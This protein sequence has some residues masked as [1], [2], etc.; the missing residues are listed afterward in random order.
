VIGIICCSR[1]EGDHILHTV[2]QKYVTAA[3]NGAGGLPLLVPACSDCIA[4]EA[5]VARLDG[6]LVPGSRSNVE[7]H[8]YGGPPSAPDTPHDPARDN[9]SL[10]LLRAA[11]KAD[12]PVLAICLGIQ[13][14]NVALGGSLHQRLYELPGR[15]DHRSP[16]GPVEVRY[17]YAAHMVNFTPGGL[18]ERLAGSASMIVNSLHHQGIDRLAPGLVVEATAPDG[19]IEAVR[20]DQ[21]QFVVG[22]Q[23]HPEHRLDEEPLSRALFAEFGEACLGHARQRHAA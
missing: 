10:P 2:S 8:Q 4:A 1:T 3:A 7:P 16:K 20:L 11:V 18:F 19:Q 17:A 21:A 14:L 15:L 13:E 23:W 9:M 22:V 12:L 5:A 6:L